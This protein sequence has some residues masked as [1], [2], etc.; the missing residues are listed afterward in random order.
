MRSMTAMR[1]TLLGSAASMCSADQGRKRRTCKW[2]EEEQGGR[3]GHTCTLGAAYTLHALL[4]TG[5]PSS[6]TGSQGCCAGCW[7]LPAAALLLLPAAPALLRTLSMPTFLPSAV[8]FF[9][10]ASS[11]SQ[12]LRQ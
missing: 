10:A 6:T 2:A 8:R 1:F 9:T 11:T 4:A 3:C 12:P 7:K 5:C